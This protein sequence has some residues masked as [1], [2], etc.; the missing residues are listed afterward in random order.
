MA[1]LSEKARRLLDE[2]NLGFLAT[3]NANGSPQVSPVWI[4]REHG[5]VLV[6]TAA[7]RARSGACVATLGSRSRW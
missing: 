7:G 2:P 4:D 3:L 5:R 6:N 1:E